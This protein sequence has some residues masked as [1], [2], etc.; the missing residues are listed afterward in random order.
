MEKS[1][2]GG[3][4]LN[5]NSHI[6]FEEPEGAGSPCHF[7]IKRNKDGSLIQNI[8]FQ[9][10]SLK[11]NG[12]NGISN[13]DL[14]NIVL[15][16]LKYFQKGKHSCRENASAIDKLEEAQMWLLKRTIEKE[17]RKAEWSLKNQ[18]G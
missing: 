7:K 18:E 16:R 13:E 9:D 6:V 17:S 1:L 14:I 5:W 2:S 3:L 12:I 11:D 15:F 4:V 8:D 10:G